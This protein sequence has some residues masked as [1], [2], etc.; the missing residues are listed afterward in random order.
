M[1][2]DNTKFVDGGEYSLMF[3]FGNNQSVTR[4]VKASFLPQN[5][6]SMQYSSLVEHTTTPHHFEN[7]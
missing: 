7:K 1:V 5:A 2:I 4:T 3:K 6:C